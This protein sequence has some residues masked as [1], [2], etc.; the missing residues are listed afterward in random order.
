MKIGLC[1]LLSSFAAAAFAAEPAGQLLRNF[2]RVVVA[3]DALPVEKKAA[4]ELA[5]SSIAI[6][7]ARM[8]GFTPT[9]TTPTSAS[10]MPP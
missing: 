5:H 6:G 4:E 7:R 2:E 10:G 3:E 8:K 1:L 9:P